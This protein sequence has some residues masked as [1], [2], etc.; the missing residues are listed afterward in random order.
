MRDPS[1]R[2][3]SL[4]DGLSPGGADRQIAAA[5]ATEQR[6][7]GRR[8]A[9][10]KS[11]MICAGLFLASTPSNA[12]NI[13][14]FTLSYACEFSATAPSDELMTTHC[15][16]AAVIMQK[17]SK[18]AYTCRLDLAVEFRRKENKSLWGIE[19]TAPY[20][21]RC[22][23]QKSI[24]IDDMQLTRQFPASAPS[25]NSLIVFVSFDIAKESGFACVNGTHLK[26]GWT[27]TACMPLQIL[28]D[29]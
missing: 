3:V 27:E 16:G 11:L 10:R 28:G 8:E 18:T 1:N 5:R 25:P 24:Q 14:I 26:T 6:D 13:D 17:Y 21:G 23:R 19:K 7:R 2:P 4:G 15:S 22:Y 9:M 29:F 20:G 12:E